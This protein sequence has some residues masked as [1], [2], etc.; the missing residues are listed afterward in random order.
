MTLRRLIGTLR[1]SLY[2][3]I[4]SV[5]LLLFKTLNFLSSM[6]LLFPDDADFLDRWPHP[7][8]SSSSSA[9]DADATDEEQLYFVP[10]RYILFLLYMS[11][12]SLHARLI[13]F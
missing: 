4:A 1:F 8:S 12:A 5:S 7:P 6:D 3:L 11:R 2:N 13:S 9:L 10:Y